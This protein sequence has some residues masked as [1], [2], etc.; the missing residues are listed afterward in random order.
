MPH[1][2]ELAILKQG[3]MLFSQRLGQIHLTLL[4]VG[5]PGAD[6]DDD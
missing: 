2:D 3:P 4:V 5:P 1:D 6:L